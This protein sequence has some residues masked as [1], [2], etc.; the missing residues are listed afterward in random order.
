MYTHANLFMYT[1]LQGVAVLVVAKEPHA[2][3]LRAQ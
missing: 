3:S 1:H 2:R